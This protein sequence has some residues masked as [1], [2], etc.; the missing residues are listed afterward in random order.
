MSLKSTL[1]AWLPQRLRTPTNAPPPEGEAWSAM[2][3]VVMGGVSYLFGVEW[4]FAPS[5]SALR[6]E[7]NEARIQGSSHYILSPMRDVVGYVHTLPKRRETPCSAAIQLSATVSDGGIELFIFSFDNEQYGLV[8]LNG[9][10][11][12]PGFDYLG[13]RS[14]VLQLAEDFKAIQQGQVIRVAGD[15]GLLEEEERLARDSVFRQPESSAKLQKLPNPTQTRILIA[16][17]VTLTVLIGTGFYMVQAE[18]ERIA[19]EQRKLEQ[20]PNRVY[21]RT[22]AK[23]LQDAGVAGPAVLGNWLSVVG[24]LP[25]HHRGWTLTKLSCTPPEC[26]GTWTRAFGNFAEFHD[27]LPFDITSSQEVQQG[28][29]PA[30]ATI[31][32]VHAV[33]A[34]QDPT[35]LERNALNEPRATLRAIASKL[36]DTSTLRNAN[37]TLTQPTLYPD[38]SPGSVGQL[39]RPVMR[40]RWSIQHEIWTLRDLPLSAYEVPELLEITFTPTTADAPPLYKLS[41]SYYAKGKSY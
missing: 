8:A 41:G 36:Q 9:S 21:E 27:D 4:R 23:A 15:A 6:H 11:P 22:I 28:E 33:Q 12:V 38:N 13:S 35:H 10:Q 3:T 34:P 32:T 40:G 29:N 26:T 30:M 25:L 20:D 24:N 16:T 31:Q 2:H 37:T 17:T 1:S 39:H 14:D 7:L 19:E 5:S 18:R